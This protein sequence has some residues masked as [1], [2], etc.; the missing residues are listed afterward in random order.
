MVPGMQQVMNRGALLSVC[1][2]TLTG[3]PLC[4]CSEQWLTGPAFY[5]ITFYFITASSHTQG[6]LDGSEPHG[7]YKAHGQKPMCCSGMFSKLYTGLA[8]GLGGLLTHRKS[9]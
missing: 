1:L 6:V 3:R 4:V 8:L 2:H 9:H 5:F 7:G